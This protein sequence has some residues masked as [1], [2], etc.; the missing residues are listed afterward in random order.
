MVRRHPI[1]ARAHVPPLSFASYAPG[2]GCSACLNCHGRGS[3]SASGDFKVTNHSP[4]Q[5][6]AATQRREG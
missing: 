2:T 5:F 6:H 3:T 4:T 1:Q